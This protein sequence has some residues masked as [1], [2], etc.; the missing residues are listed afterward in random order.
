MN[1][2]MTAVALLA[3][4]GSV[5]AQS[6]PAGGRLAGTVVGDDGAPMDGATI[7]Y[8]RLPRFAR[9]TDLKITKTDPGSTGMRVVGPDGK[10]ALTGL[11]AGDYQV[12]AFGPLPTQIS[13][14]SWDPAPGVSLGNG[15]AIT[16]LIHQVHEGTTVTIRVTD[17]H[18][19]IQIPDAKGPAVHARRF[20]IGAWTSSAYIR[21]TL[22]SNSPT[23]KVYS[24]LVPKH[25]STQFFI[26][27]EFS[28]T[29]SAGSSVEVRRPTALAV[30]TGT[31]DQLTV[32]L[33]VL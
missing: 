8:R 22:F 7:R 27:T 2:V 20:L 25:R 12:C 33:A 14:C 32:D 4:I 17:L 30:S 9:G 1:H 31:L 23:E 29:T 24:V 28:V 11:T 16:G 5:A 10:Y 6:L 19:K 21:A 18:S 15:G 13:S 3:L 26:D